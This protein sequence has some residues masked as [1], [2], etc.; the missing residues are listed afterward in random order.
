M[1][2]VKD[3][4]ERAQ[5]TLVA[6]RKLTIP[7]IFMIAAVSFAAS[8]G[9]NWAFTRQ[10][11]TGNTVDLADL[12]PRVRALEDSKLLQGEHL[13]TLGAQVGETKGSLETSRKDL[14]DRMTAVERKLD[15]LVSQIAGIAGAS[16]AKLPGDKK[17]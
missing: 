14:G 10:E 15:V 9:A 1:S 5:D 7:T 11:L 17:P 8:V 13:L 3:M 2:W 16:T 12:K 6:P 4:G